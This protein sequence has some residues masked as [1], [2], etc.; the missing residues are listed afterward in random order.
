MLSK[1]ADLFSVVKGWGSG[2]HASGVRYMLPSGLP[3]HG[4]SSAY[5]SGF[6]HTGHKNNMRHSSSLQD[7]SSY[8]GLVFDDGNLNGTHSKPPHPLLRDNV[9]SSFSKEKSLPG[10]TAF[11]RRKWIRR[12]L[13]LL[14]LLL[15]LLL[16]YMVSM[17]AYAYW[18]R[19]TSKFYV[20]L[21]CGSTGTRV[22][23]YQASLNYKKDGSLPL[24]IRS[25]NEGV[26]KKPR[27]Q[28]GRAYDRMETEPGFD[29]LVRNVSGLTAAINPLV[30]WAKKQIPKQSH[31]TTSLFLYATAGVRRLPDADSRWL[32]DNAW[33]I[34]KTSPFFCKRE[35]VK[36]ISGVEEAYYGWAALNYRTHMLGVMSKKATF[37]A[38]DLGG[39]SLQVTFESKDNM[40]NSSSLKLRIGVIDHHLNAYSLS[41]YG[42]NDAFDK[43]VAR[44]VMALPESK[45]TDL[46]NGNVELKHPCLHSGYKEQYICSQCA[47]NFKE[48]GSPVVQG[49]KIGKGGKPGISL[50]LVGAPNWEE[51]SALAKVAVNISEWSHRSPGIDCDLQPCALPDNLA[52][53][54]GHFYAM[55]G[56]F[57]VYRFFNLTADASLDDVLEKGREFCEKT[58]EVAKNSVAPQ[59]FIE[60]YCFRAPYITLLLR[61]G[62]HITDNQ[63]TIGSGGITWTLGVALLESGKAFP[64]RM[65]LHSYE[66]LQMRI[67]PVLLIAILLTSLFVLLCALSRIYNW[68][69]RFFRRP[70]LPL[71]KHNSTSAAS[72]LNVP[73]PFRFQRWSPISSGKHL[74]RLV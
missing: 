12:I 52:R 40:R 41:G 54:H 27:S 2:P 71:F 33:S 45:S 46:V 4:C 21:D 8:H 23:V 37:G 38:L 31:K 63:I 7:L 32:L 14:C 24:V 39:S 48:G 51:C 49:R 56:F 74:Y 1:I 65:G 16:I 72:V 3:S 47:S 55:S 44:L 30:W 17:Y 42:L 26:K 53:P 19:G 67:N 20:V 69:P 9:G 64:M 15:F 59:P 29:K 68:M 25:F 61:E 43:T 70:Y 22:Y 50:H 5:T 57:V 34:L 35:W 10:G 36:I 6:T 13:V 58:W 11:P 60:Q 18:S 66:I 28:S 62:L 73:S